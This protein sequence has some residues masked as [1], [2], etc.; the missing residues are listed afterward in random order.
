MSHWFFGGAAAFVLGAAASLLNY[1]ILKAFM[2]KNTQTVMAA[3]GLRQAVNIAL[4]VAVYLLAP[5]TPW[6]RAVLLVGAAAGMSA[7]L[8]Y[9]TFRETRGDKRKES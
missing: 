6:S 1:R 3:V 5:L 7:F 2:K 8:F 4:L 9:F